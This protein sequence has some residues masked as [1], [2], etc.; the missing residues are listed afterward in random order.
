MRSPSRW[1]GRISAALRTH[2]VRWLAGGL[3]VAA[4]LSACGAGEETADGGRQLVPQEPTGPVEPA[5]RPTEPVAFEDGC[6]T[7]ECHALHRE[8]AHVHT[9]VAEDACPT[10]HQPDA[11]DHTYPLVAG[12][13]TL[14]GWCHE[15]GW[16]REHRHAVLDS[17]GCLACHDPH[18]SEGPSLLTAGDVPRTCEQCHPPR[19]GF[20]QHTSCGEG[21]CLACHDPHESD[22]PG[23]VLGGEG[24][25][26]CRNCH[27]DLVETFEAGQHSHLEVEGD[28]RACHEAHA[29]DF[30]GH[31]NAEAAEG[32]LSCH[33]EIG[34]RIADATTSHDA[35]LKGDRCLS[36]HDP[37]ASNI[38]MLLRGDLVHVCLEC[39]QESVETA[40]GRQIRAMTAEIL[41]APFEHGPVQSGDCGVCHAIHGS[42][43]PR[44]LTGPVSAALEGTPDADVYS[45]CFECHLPDLALA[46]RTDFA[47]AFRDGD[48]NMHYLHLDK[49]ENRRPCT[50][51]HAV[52][53]SSLPRH[54]AESVPYQDSDWLMPIGF[55][56][57]EDGGRCAPGCH[58]PL[59]Y[60]RGPSTPET[61]GSRGEGR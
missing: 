13:D 42:T 2:P 35:V 20:F 24:R 40:D 38:P 19:E 14:C 58:E 52:H 47:T 39:H 50:S 34:E 9:P 51:C 54:I 23:L 57:T 45:L 25:G 30:R 61:E 10:C 37:H 16:T 49:D 1:I 27:V 17:D 4:G 56:L 11:G 12:T 8:S 43:H 28:C 36:C 22:E 26:N 7:A 48:R 46:E 31:L 15:T 6:V 53:G 29:T 33:E 3:L 59:S 55:E 18:A 32:C 21:L 44:L 60:S 5:A 41:S